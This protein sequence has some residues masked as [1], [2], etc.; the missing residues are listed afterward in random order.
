MQTCNEVVTE[1][2]SII[3]INESVG[4][5]FAFLKQYMNYCMQQELLIDMVK[6]LCFIIDDAKIM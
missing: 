6:R 5:N 2:V 1:L 4:A 3:L